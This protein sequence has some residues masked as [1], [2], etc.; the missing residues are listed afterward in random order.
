MA[1]CTRTIF[2]PCDTVI[3]PSS[4]SCPHYSQA[5]S[6]IVRNRAC[7]SDGICH[8]SLRGTKKSNGFSA[9]MI[10]Q[11]WKS[12]FAKPCRTNE[13][14][15]PELNLDRGYAG[16]DKAVDPFL[17]GYVRIF[18]PRIMQLRRHHVRWELFRILGCC[19][20][21]AMLL[22][23]HRWCCVI[24]H[25]NYVAV[26]NGHLKATGSTQ[27]WAVETIREPKKGSAR[28]QEVKFAGIPETR[29]YVHFSVHVHL[30]VCL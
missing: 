10:Q 24:L 14:M 4:L 17:V 21:G 22:Q 30:H 3:L 23:R 1:L 28:E 16:T 20:T 27:Y 26:A 29:V 8:Q 12:A 13:L 18:V 7:W 6:S 15:E 25:R 9:P 11:G 5:I 19:T 2:G